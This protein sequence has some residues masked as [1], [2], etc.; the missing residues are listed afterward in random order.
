MPYTPQ[1]WV[2]GPGG[3]TKINATRL[4]YIETGIETAQA[5]AE[6]AAGTVVG[7]AGTVPV[8]NGTINVYTALDSADVPSVAFDVTSGGAY[9]FASTD[10]G[11]MKGS[12]TSDTAAMVWTIPLN[13]TVPFPVGTAIKVLQRGTGQITIAGAAG[14]TLNAY[15]SAYK[16]AGQNASI[17]VVKL[18]T[19]TWLV[20]G[21][22]N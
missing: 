21:G 13:A 7:P 19:D 18:F 9:T 16:T 11:T 3:G 2:N 14:V 22:I 8:S 15:A 1:T 6:S 5:T 10:A 20:E 4:T 17:T 12:L